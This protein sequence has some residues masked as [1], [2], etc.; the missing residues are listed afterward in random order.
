MQCWRGAANCLSCRVMAGVRL[1]GV[2]LAG[3][4]RLGL[5]RGVGFVFDVLLPPR[6]PACR[7]IVAVEGSFCAGCWSDLAFITAPMCA[8]CGTPFEIDRGPGVRCGACLAEPP[9]FAAARAALVYGGSARA[10]LLGFKHGDREHLC[11]VMA[12]QMVRAAG[13]WLSA[14]TVLVPVPLHRWRLWRRGYNQA[15]LLAA[16]VAKR[17][18][19]QLSVD[20]L[21]RTR[22]TLASKAMTRMQRARNVRGA[23]T[24]ARADAV[25]G[26]H[27]VL[28]DDVLTSGA[29]ANACTRVL[30]RAGAERVDVLTWARVVRVD[31]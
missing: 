12:P 10:V 21:V 20:A 5:R 18:P 14:E 2:R 3:A 6:C 31:G 1:A 15:A 16:A 11:R 13:D 23:F 17:T 19:A 9:R 26:R 22:A 4:V 28:V 30:L 7:E 27:V 29:T 25:K 24:V 8:G